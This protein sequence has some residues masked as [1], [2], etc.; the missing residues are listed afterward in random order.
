MIEEL[1]AHM[2]SDIAKKKKEREREREKEKL[3]NGY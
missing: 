2:P 3:N 1:R